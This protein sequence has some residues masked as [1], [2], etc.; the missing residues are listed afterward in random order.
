MTEKQKKVY[1]A[2]GGQAVIEGVMMKG[3]DGKTA[4]VCR[5]SNGELVTDIRHSIPLSKK[6]P[7]LGLPVLRGVVSFIDSMFGGI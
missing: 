2:Y 4:V 5:K 6:Y 7:I 1:T 3:P